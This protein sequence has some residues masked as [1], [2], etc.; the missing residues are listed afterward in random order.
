[1][2]TRVDGLVL[3]TVFGAV[4][5][6]VALNMLFRSGAPALRESLPALPGQV[7]MAGVIGCLSV[8]MGIGGGT[9]GVPTM[10]AFNV[11]AHRAVGTAAAFGLIIALPGALMMLTP[12]TPE[13]APPG[14]IG[15]VNLPGFVVIVPM[16]TLLA[17]VGV[18]L[19]ARLDG[20][21][22]KKVFAVFLIVVGLRMLWQSLSP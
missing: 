22:L 1:M 7:I 8:M 12:A 6:A 21:V 4:A 19:G 20:A 14:T 9:L 3:S 17:P 2:A 18:R 16:T 13:G 11:R 10:T 15:L 5:I